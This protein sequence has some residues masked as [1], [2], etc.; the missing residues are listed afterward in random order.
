MN[1]PFSL[2]INAQKTLSTEIPTEIGG[3]CQEETLEDIEIQ[4]GQYNNVEDSYNNNNDKNK[5]KTSNSTNSKVKRTRTR[6]TRTRTTTTRHT[7]NR[8]II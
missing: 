6:T 4:Q 8:R 2:A 3:G 7:D 1:D 5:N